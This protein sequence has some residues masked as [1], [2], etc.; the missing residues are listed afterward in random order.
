MNSS[1]LTK[2]ILGSCRLGES[3][4]PPVITQHHNQKGLLYF[5]YRITG[6]V[7]EGFSIVVSGLNF[8]SLQT[9]KVERLKCNPKREVIPDSES[10]KNANYAS[11]LENTIRTA[12][13][14]RTTP[15]Q[16]KLLD[17]IYRQVME[18]S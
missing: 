3:V 7:D 12:I 1:E 16:K 6:R 11:G 4:F 14:N 9:G 5:T 17:R 15:D 13:E 2:G 10:V 8:C 18:E